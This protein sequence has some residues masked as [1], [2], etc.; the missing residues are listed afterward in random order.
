[1]LAAQLPY[2]L[3]YIDAEGTEAALTC[4]STMRGGQGCG[5]VIVPSQGGGRPAGIAHHER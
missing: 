2:L 5:A 4:R 1:M 3:G